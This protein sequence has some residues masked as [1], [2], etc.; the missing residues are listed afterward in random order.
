[1]QVQIWV[2]NLP[3]PHHQLSRFILHNGINLLEHLLAQSPIHTQ[4]LDRPKYL[5]RPTRARNRTRDIRIRQ[6]PRHTQ[7]RDIGPQLLRDLPESPDLVLLLRP[8]LGA[9]RLEHRLDIRIV[10]GAQAGVLG[11]AVDVL[12]RE[13]AAPERGEDGQP[14]A[15]ARV[16]VCVFELVVDLVAAQERVAW[17]FDN[18]ADEP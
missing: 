14:Q 9:D 2:F 10:G 5:L 18:G 13:Q 17:L 16:Q 12:A 8:R 3:K 11:H 15:A 1:M 4:R 7:R 6:H